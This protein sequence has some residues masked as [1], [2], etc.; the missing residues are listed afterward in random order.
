MRWRI[1]AS[2]FGGFIELGYLMLYVDFVTK[3]KHKRLI[4]NEK[5]LIL[6]GYLQSYVRFT[7]QIYFI[8]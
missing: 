1:V 2:D 5:T 7:K 8:M 6:S 3:L 4:T